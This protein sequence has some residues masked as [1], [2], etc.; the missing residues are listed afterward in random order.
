MQF[1]STPE[2]LQIPLFDLVMCLSNTTD[3]V[4]SKVADHQQRVAYIAS[5]LAAELGL[6]RDDQADLI[7]AAVV[8]DFGALSLQERLECLDFEV[9]TPHHHSESAYLLLRRFKP[10][11]QVAEIVRHHHLPW[12]HGAGQRRFGRPVPFASHVLHFADRVEVLLHELPG[13][14]RSADAIHSFL[15]T[16]IGYL[17]APDLMEAFRV[18]ASRD[19]FWF[20]LDAPY[21]AMVL[22]ERGS[23]EPIPLD[24]DGLTAMGRLFGQAI[25]FRSR[26]T[27]VHSGGVAAVSAWLAARAGMPERACKLMKVAGHMHDFG[28]LAVSR[29]ILEKPG[30]LDAYELGQIHRHPYY[31]HRLLDP[32]VHLRDLNEW[33]SFHHERL[34]GQGYPFRL[35]GDR[36]PLGA[37]VLAVGDIFTAL[38]EDR[39][40]RPGLPPEEALALLEREAE[41]GGV[42]GAIVALLR[43]SFSEVD[44]LRRRAQ[45]A[46]QSEFEEF[47]SGLA[48]LASAGGEIAD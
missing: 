14:C 12:R 47:T 10:F 18:L 34:D 22:A 39:P 27:A 2:H 13:G 8:H 32:I 5:G 1:D 6:S 20:D 33:I 41:T 26:F 11:A 9:E 21:L 29:E 4:S 46:A 38:T 17:L 15:A 43:S 24:Y 25:D 37:R 30:A 44:D 42:D 35:P 23:R 28:K 3:L 16:K 40:Y 7:L 19:Y 48:A 31:A 45:A 36:I